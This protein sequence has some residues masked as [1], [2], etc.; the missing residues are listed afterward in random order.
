MEVSMWMS[1]HLVDVD[2]VVVFTLIGSKRVGST[3][4]AELTGLE[5]VRQASEL[6]YFS[7]FIPARR[8]AGRPSGGLAI[9]CKQAAPNKP[10][11]RIGKFLLKSWARLP[12]LA[13]DPFCW[14]ETGI[15][16][17]TIFQ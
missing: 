11:R 9:L 6:G 10:P 13:R 2:A 3:M 17:R 15:S 5:I 16:N 7:S 4:N 12:A 1:L 14:V 8:T